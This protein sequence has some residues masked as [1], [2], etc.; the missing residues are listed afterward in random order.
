MRQN[1]VDYSRKEL[2]DSIL[3]LSRRL[4][5]STTD[6]LLLDRRRI[7]ILREL[8]LRADSTKPKA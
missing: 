6:Y 3:E 5:A 4:D 2:P 8:E 7:E 1:R